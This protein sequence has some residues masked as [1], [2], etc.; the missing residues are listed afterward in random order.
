M[1]LSHTE[2]RG[3]CW[4]LTLGEVERG[5]GWMYR[6]RS[7]IHH[8]CEDP[9]GDDA[10]WKPPSEA[11]VSRFSDPGFL[12][13]LPWCFRRHRF[14]QRC[15]PRPVKLGSLLLGQLLLGD[16]LWGERFL[17][18]RIF[19]EKKCGLNHLVFWTQAAWMDAGC[20][21]L[22]CG[23]KPQCW[24]EVDMERPPQ[25]CWSE[26]KKTGSGDLDLQMLTVRILDFRWF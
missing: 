8:M 12:S 24:G 5:V 9:G 7:S 3:S 25:K 2:V 22:R 14:R 15:P 13:E 16:G 6:F 21:Y 19:G 20:C 1:S 23:K 18:E 26:G 11:G 10:P 4:Q 17:G